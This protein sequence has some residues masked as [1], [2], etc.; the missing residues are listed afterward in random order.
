MTIRF[1]D[2]LGQGVILEYEPEDY[3]SRWVWGKLQADGRV[4]IAKAFWFNRTD[5][6]S[7]PSDDDFEGIDGFVYR[8]RLGSRRD[9]YDASRANAW[10]STSPS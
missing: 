2:R 1:E 7:E 9:G 4:R 10:G 6:M 8:F 5:L 3:D